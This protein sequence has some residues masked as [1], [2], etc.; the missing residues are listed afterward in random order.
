M[1]YVTAV[2]LKDIESACQ[3]IAQHVHRTPVLTCSTFDKMSNFKLFFKCE[4]LQK[5][6]SFKARGALNAILK[7]RETAAEVRTG[8]RREDPLLKL[9]L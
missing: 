7:A 9:N 6:G 1:S 4:N 3:R 2:T 5:T 8:D